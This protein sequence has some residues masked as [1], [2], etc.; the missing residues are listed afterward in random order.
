MI[1]SKPLR[2]GHDQTVH[3]A[4]HFAATLLKDHLAG[5]VEEVRIVPDAAMGTEPQMLGKVIAG[6][7]EMT[8]VTVANAADVIPELGFFSLP[9]LFSDAEHFERSISS[10]VFV[11]YLRALVERRC[12]D[13]EVIAIITPGV[14]NLYS[15]R[16]VESLDDLERMRVRVMASEIDSEVWR[17]W[18]TTPI[19]IPFRQ[20]ADAIRNGVVDA[21]EDTSAVYHAQRHYELA[22]NFAL[23][24]HQWSVGL[25]LMNRR[26]YTA[27][28]PKAARQL[29]A[30]GQGMGAD[31]IAYAVESARTAIQ[32]LEECRNVHITRPNTEVFKLKSADMKRDVST[33]LRMTDLLDFLGA[34]T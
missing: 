29:S 17:S 34:S 19:P 21:A 15:V 22:G 10:P 5:S 33:R 4:Y 20:I 3:D 28:E 6:N 2:I 8:I 18:G 14:R 7:L 1:S 31:V 26:G 11:Q 27:L 25:V 30:F 13:L 16:P 12:K 24:G 23:T 32:E 9:Y